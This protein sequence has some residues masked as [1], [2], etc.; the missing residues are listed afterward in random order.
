MFPRLTK[1]LAW[2]ALALGVSGAVACSATDPAS[3]GG[4]A[5]GT[6]A[7]V[8]CKT[9]LVECTSTS[10]D[11]NQ[12]VACRDQWQECQMGKGLQIGECS[13]PGD[14][15]ACD[16][17]RSRLT[18]CTSASDD[19]PECESQFSVCKA[20]LITRGDIQ[21]QCRAEDAATPEIGCGIC[22][23]DYAV[24]LSDVS[25]D[26]ALQI[27]ADKRVACLTANLVPVEACAA[28]AGDEG[29]SL[30]TSQH[31]Q[32]AASGGPSC[33]EG[34]AQCSG[35][36]AANVTCELATGEGG[37]GEG[38]GGQGGAGGGETSGCG[39]DLC[40]TGPAIE[41][42]SCSACATEVCDQDSWCCTNEWDS[43]C[44]EIAG[45][46]ESCGCS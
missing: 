46:L 16:L 4:F 24:C 29:C 3:D 7:C 21:A 19:T 1:T 33:S 26:N 34:F 28:P 22:Q 40:T 2:L 45:G 27:C 13:N 23:D 36:V 5:Q 12:F 9:I 41:D 18:E 20:F 25:Q 39:Q 10:I 8:E 35:T 30:C 43:L 11:E 37:A 42:S 14:Q 44:I 17:C 31:D 6:D 32:C 15:E 38:G